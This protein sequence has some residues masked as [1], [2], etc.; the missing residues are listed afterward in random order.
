MCGT[1]LCSACF[2]LQPAGGTAPAPGGE[3][4]LRLTDRG[5]VAIAP[6]LGRDVSMVHGHLLRRDNDAYVIAMTSVEFSGGGSR[7]LPGDSTRISGGDVAELFVNRVSKPRSLVV[8]AAAA[9]ALGAMAYEALKPT[10]TPDQPTDVLP[11]SGDKQR[12]GA[13]ARLSVRSS[14]VS[15]IAHSSIVRRLFRPDRWFSW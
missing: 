8:A 12:S 2:S 14:D 1:L 9:V 15:A 3:I 5:R 10:P 11:G 7:V 6:T 13:R 4:A